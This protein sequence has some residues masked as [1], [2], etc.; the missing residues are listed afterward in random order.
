[1][2]LRELL[3]LAGAGQLLLVAASGF[4]PRALGWSEE[5]KP[6]RPLL[7]QM[8]WTYAAYILGINLGFGLLAVLAPDSLLDGSL[9]AAAV[10]GF[11]ALYWGARVLIQFFYFDRSEVRGRPLFVLAEVALVALFLFLTAVYGAAAVQNVQRLM[12]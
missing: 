4:I 5:L 7:R 3:L 12:G 8:F 10:T 1:M 11:T 9:L 2:R 6:L